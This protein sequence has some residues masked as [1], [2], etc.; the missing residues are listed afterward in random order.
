MAGWLA[1]AAP[2]IPEIIH[3]AR[4]LFTRGSAK[5]K[6][7][8]VITQQIVELQNVATQNA[9]SIKLLATEMQHTIEALQ[10]G[11]AEM[12]KKLNRANTLLIISTTMA[13]LAFCVAV[14]ALVH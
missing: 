7:P 8:D 5:D 4:P 13:G 12:E 10:S 2:Y 11:A 9:E 3:L 6:E 14:Y 1:I